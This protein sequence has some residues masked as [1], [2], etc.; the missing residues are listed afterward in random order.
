ML[1]LK[2]CIAALHKCYNVHTMNVFDAN[3]DSNSN[4]HL[5]AQNIVTSLE[6]TDIV[7]LVWY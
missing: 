5:P 1:F 6:Q 4:I 3:H 7:T 2:F